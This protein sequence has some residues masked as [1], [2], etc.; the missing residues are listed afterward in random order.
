L[1]A[2]GNKTPGS[3]VGLASL[4]ATHNPAGFIVSTGMKVYGE[5]SG[6]DT[7]QGRAQQ[8]AKQ[9]G[10]QLKQRFQQQGWISGS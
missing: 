8:I 5:K 2:T 7:V 4:I 1:D 10:D 6:S 9:I 3:A